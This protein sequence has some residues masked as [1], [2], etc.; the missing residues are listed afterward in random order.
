M[1]AGAYLDLAEGIALGSGVLGLKAWNVSQLSVVLSTMRS[2]KQCRDA[3][4]ACSAS[5]IAC[6]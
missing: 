1:V 5:L 3:R 4:T 6:T 2:M